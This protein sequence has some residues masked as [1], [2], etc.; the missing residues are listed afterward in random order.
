M[1]VSNLN[2]RAPFSGGAYSIMQLRYSENNMGIFR[3]ARFTRL[4]STLPPSHPS[5]ARTV[6]L[7]PRTAV[8]RRSC[9]CA[10]IR[11]FASNCLPHSEPPASIPF[12]RAC[13]TPCAHVF[14]YNLRL[15]AIFIAA[16]TCSAPR[17]GYAQPVPDDNRSTSVL[18]L[19][20]PGYSPRRINVGGVT[21]TPEFDFGTTYDTNVYAS[22]VNQRGDAVFL[23]RPMVA[24]EK[25]GSRV[26]WR[27]DAYALARRYATNTRENSDTYGI[28]AGTTVTATRNITV[29]AAAGFRRATENRADPEIQQN[30]QAGPPLFDVLSGDLN[31]AVAMG[32][33]VL[34]A[35]GQAERYN[36]RSGPNTDR[37]FTSYRA[38]LRLLYQFSGAI[39]GFAQGYVNQRNFRYRD[40]ISGADRDSRTTGGLVGMQLDPGGKLRG[41]V[42]VG[43]FRYDPADPQRTP[44][45]GFALEG[46]LTYSP[47]RRTAVILDLFSGDVATARN[48]ASGR[49][50]R[51]AKL[52]LQQEVRH[53][54]LAT[55]GAR[56]GRTNYRGVETRLTT[57]GADAEVE[58][59][60]NRHLSAA[61]TGQISKRSGGA[62][63]DRFGRTRVGAEIRYR[64]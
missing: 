20:R 16:L 40:P 64:F 49:V 39:S 19:E 31:V 13:S 37:D 14:G 11:R 8:E 58:F 54:L 41:N 15:V 62:Q 9:T 30:P 21:I 46:S 5:E 2:V 47:R 51:R 7:P 42:G 18:D 24:A 28:S 17:P 48:G 55:L 63:S 23:V 50:D 12:D 22:H 32:R 26:R 27:A 35:R 45:N 34:L 60:M 57:V 3:P 44:F 1:E 52:T 36:F 53:N 6:H 38:S 33:M 10:N 4:T 25:S 43:L 59:L 56:Y 29:G 61:L